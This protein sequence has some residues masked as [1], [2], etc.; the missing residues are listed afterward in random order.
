MVLDFGGHSMGG[1]YGMMRRTADGRAS[2]YSPSQSDFGLRGG[3]EIWEIEIGKAIDEQMTKDW[4]ARTRFPEQ[5]RPKIRAAFLNEFFSKKAQLSL[6][7][8]KYRLI[9]NLD[10]IIPEGEK[11]FYAIELLTHVLEDAWQKAYRAILDLA[12]KEIENVVR[13]EKFEGL[14]ILLSGG[15]IANLQARTELI[16]FCNN[17]GRFRSHGPFKNE[18]TVKLMKDIQTAHWKWTIAQGAAKALATT[19]DVAEFFD[20]G[21]AL[22]IQCSTRTGNWTAHTS[23]RAKLLFCK[24]C[25]LRTSV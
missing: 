9:A 20:R 21:A 12:K 16:D 15:S 11:P 2:I 4:N 6:D 23:G 10:G 17:W 25:R 14:F 7:K 22:G 5:H 24:V 18:V 8:P 3:Y 19:M 13:K 1:S